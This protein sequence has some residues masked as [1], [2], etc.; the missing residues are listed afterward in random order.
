MTPTK[1]WLELT[2]GLWLITS[3]RLRSKPNAD[4]GDTLPSA[5]VA[6]HGG[7][8]LS[9]FLLIFPDVSLVIL[10][11]FLTRSIDMVLSSTY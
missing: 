3:H 5:A 9:T 11:V 6:A 10:S 1:P 7:V 2:S 8:S 4:L